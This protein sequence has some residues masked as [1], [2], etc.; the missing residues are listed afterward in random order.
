MRT[1]TRTLVLLVALATAASLSAAPQGSI[2]NYGTGCGGGPLA[3]AG[4][5]SPTL[6]NSFDLSLSNGR[7]SSVGAIFLGATSKNQPLAII[8]MQ[9][10]SLYTDILVTQGVALDI[11]GAST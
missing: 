4:S 1:M 3:I 6:G 8:G 9:G 7:P 5:G 10:C 2:V 11:N